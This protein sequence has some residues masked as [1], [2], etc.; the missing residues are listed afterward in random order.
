MKT[1]ASYLPKRMGMGTITIRCPQELL[2]EIRMAAETLGVS[3]NRLTVA[4]IRCG[5]DVEMVRAAVATYDQS[6]IDAALREPT[7]RP[8]TKKRLARRGVKGGAE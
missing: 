1:L 7:T 8:R 6:G 5:L 4:A 3:A 2:A